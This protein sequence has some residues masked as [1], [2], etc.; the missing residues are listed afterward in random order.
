MAKNG[1]REYEIISADS[2]I[3]EPPDLWQKWMPEKLR[4]KAPQ[5]VKDEEG[6][7]A[8]TYEPGGWPEPLGLVTCVG[9]RP[10]A[11][12]WTG[13]KY[14]ETI[15][16]SCHDGKERLKILDIDGVDAEILYPPQRA[17]SYFMRNP[18]HELQLAGI[19]AYNNWLLDDFCAADPERL[20]GQAQMPNVGIDGAVEEL[21]RAKRKGAKGVIITAWPSGK[22]ALTKA[23]DPFWA[24]AEAEDMPV[25]IHLRLA[26]IAQARQK[27]EVSGAAIGAGAFTTMPDIMIQFI[28][29]GVHDRFPGL[30]VA[31]V[32]TGAGWIPHFLEMMDDRYWRN[33]VW[34]KL[35]LAE[36]PSKY[37]YDHWLATFIVD[38][39]GVQI[40]HAVG[41]NNLSWS[42]DFPHHGNDWPYS[43]KVIDEMLVNVP[44]DERDKI[45]CRNAAEFWNLV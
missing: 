20:I 31:S 3:V 1:K 35:D 26:A 34:A 19:Q 9:V 39:I 8:W 29:S 41:I 15:H 5:L 22:E 18:D 37:Y 42:T 23:D 45:I 21:K 38:H 44:A 4:D 25:S 28:F 14:G 2:H 7:D 43:R 13:A 32:E 27:V 17:T 30:K 10:E 40:R 11:L 36:V 6:G 16:P 24:A 33:R 12:K